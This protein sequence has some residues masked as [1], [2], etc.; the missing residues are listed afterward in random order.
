MTDFEHIIRKH[1]NEAYTIEE[2]NNFSKYA[3][4]TGEHRLLNFYIPKVS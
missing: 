1:I 3:Y 2:V 4:P